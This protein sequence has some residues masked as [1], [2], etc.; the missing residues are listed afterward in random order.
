MTTPCFLRV[1]A[2]RRDCRADRGNGP[3]LL[4]V[5]PQSNFRTQSL[6]RK[7]V[8]L[9]GSALGSCRSIVCPST[10]TGQTQMSK[11]LSFC[12]GKSRCSAHFCTPQ[13]LR[14]GLGPG[15]GRCNP[16]KIFADSSP[17]SPPGQSKSPH[18]PCNLGKQCPRYVAVAVGFETSPP[19]VGVAKNRDCL[20]GE[21]AWS[22]PFCRAKD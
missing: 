22:L 14:P 7:Q 21:A 18:L 4:N 15:D 9:P 8:I 17:T 10:S 19:A 16:R 13:G 6:N 11:P 20:L 1:S 5:P 2:F 3:L 12:A